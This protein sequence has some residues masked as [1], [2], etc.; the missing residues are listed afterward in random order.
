MMRALTRPPASVAPAERAW[1]EVSATPTNSPREEATVVVTKSPSVEALREMRGP[2]RAG[3]PPEM[4]FF[5]TLATTGIISQ[6]TWQ[7][8]DQ[9]SN[10]AAGTGQNQRLGREI[11]IH[12]M[13]MTLN[14]SDLAADSLFALS[15]VCRVD[16]TVASSDIFPSSGSTR[17]LL[18]Y[19]NPLMVSKV[20]EHRISTA[21]TAAGGAFGTTPSYG[22]LCWVVDQTWEKGFRLRYDAGGAI[23]GASPL[24]LFATNESSISVDVGVQIW[25]TDE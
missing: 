2:R 12:R 8:A 13:R 14:P 3:S 16:P 23:F 20:Y 10:I 19:P 24:V 11:R 9:L 6:N 21:M 22:A 7:S 18:E 1:T 25:F 17:A 15:F 5:Q 4:K